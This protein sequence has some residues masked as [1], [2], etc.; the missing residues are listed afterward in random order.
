MKLVPQLILVLLILAATAAG[1]V[2]LVRSSPDRG[3]EIVLPD[4]TAAP[5]VVLKAYISGTVHNPRVYDM[6]EGDRLA[7]LVEAA[8][9]ATDDADLSAVNLFARIEDEGHWHIPRLD[10]TAA[11]ATVPTVSTRMDVNTAGVA[12]RVALPHIG[13]IIAQ[14]I[15]DYREANR[16]FSN[17]EDLLAVQGHRPRHTD[18]HP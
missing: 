5:V 10:E 3:I 2:W 17:V 12:Q 8:G 18:G 15:I 1:I 4:P 14:R 7:E 9:A 6:T 11:V 16:P 13:A